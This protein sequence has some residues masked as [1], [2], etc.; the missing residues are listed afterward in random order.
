[1]KNHKSAGTN[2]ILNEIIKAT[3][4]E[5]L[6]FLIKLF[7]LIYSTGIFPEK[8]VESMIKPLFKGGNLFDPSDYIGISLTSCLDK[9]FCSFLNTALTKKSWRLLKK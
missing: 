1:M 4:D 8:L 5:I 7:N 9:L 6:P 2:G 3:R